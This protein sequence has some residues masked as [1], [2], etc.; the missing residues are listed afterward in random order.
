MHLSL[1]K[2]FPLYIWLLLFAG[3]FSV[4]LTSAL[5][6]GGEGGLLFR[7]TCSVV[8]WG[9]RN[10]ANKYHWH[11][12]GVFAVSRPHLD[13]PLLTAC[14]LSQSILLRLQV[15]MQGARPGLHFPGLSRSGS[16]SPV[17][18]KGA[19]SVGPAFCA[20]PGTSLGFRARPSPVCHVCLWGADLWLRP[21]RQMST[22]QNLRK[23][24]VRNWKP[25]RSLVEDALSGTEFAPFSLWLAPA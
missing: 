13:L 24:L 22:V 21:S 20:V 17:L 3:L 14:V 2:R 8:L 23:S 19:D 1:A 7:L 18:H 12:W 11:V 6:Q 4:Y 5:T 16:S 15:A 9:G 10:T 25:V